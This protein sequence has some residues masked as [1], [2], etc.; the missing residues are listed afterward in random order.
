M[1][2]AVT[3]A[4]SQ[5]TQGPED[6]AQHYR[7]QQGTIH[8]AVSAAHSDWTVQPKFTRLESKELQLKVVDK[9]RPKPKVCS[10]L[11]GAAGHRAPTCIFIANRDARRARLQ[12]SCINTKPALP[13]QLTAL[14]PQALCQPRSPKLS[15]PHS[16]RPLR[17]VTSVST[18]RLG[19]SASA[20]ARGH[21]LWVNTPI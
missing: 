16:A 14:K 19:N 10:V 21:V 1:K 5:P 6:T 8:G 3:T 12:R 2:W 18:P 4:L 15:Q 9:Y 7:S 13:K 17:L 11:S 20:A